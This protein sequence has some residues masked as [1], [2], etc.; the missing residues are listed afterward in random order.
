MQVYAM[1]VNAVYTQL[2]KRH[3]NKTQTYGSPARCAADNV[4][5]HEVY[6]DIGVNR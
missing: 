1:S 4:H 6:V 3:V 2:N 5:V